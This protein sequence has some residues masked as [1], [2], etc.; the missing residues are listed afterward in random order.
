[1]SP[2]FGDLVWI[3]ASFP[4]DANNDRIIVALSSDGGGSTSGRRSAIPSPS[5]VMPWVCVTG[6]HLFASWFDRRPSSVGTDNSLTDFYLGRMDFASFGPKVSANINMSGTPIA[7]ALRDGRMVRGRVS[8][9][10][11]VSRRPTASAPTAQCPV[12]A[13]NCQPG[14]VPSTC[15]PNFACVAEQWLAQVRQLQ[16]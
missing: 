9:Y 6:K 4:S 14:A 16:R 1:V 15:S 13:G 3:G 8:G 12:T 7:N 2:D 11:L 10:H 5:E